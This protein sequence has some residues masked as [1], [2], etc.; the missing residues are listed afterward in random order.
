MVTSKPRRWSWRAA[1]SPTAPQPS[2][3]ARRSPWASAML[4]AI[5][6][7]PHDSDIPEPPWP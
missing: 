6:P 7:V 1:V 4:A 2:T 5:A 3:A